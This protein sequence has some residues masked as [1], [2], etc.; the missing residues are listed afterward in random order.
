[1]NAYSKHRSQFS[2]EAQ[3]VQV[4]ISTSRSVLVK[5]KKTDYQTDGDFWRFRI[6]IQ[7]VMQ[8]LKVS[9]R[10][11]STTKFIGMKKSHNY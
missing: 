6:D 8:E 2:I 9:Q 3:G 11:T 4:R 1:V 7:Q 5:T 10:I